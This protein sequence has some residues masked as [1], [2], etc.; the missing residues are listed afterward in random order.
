M[1]AG[2]KTQDNEMLLFP[3][4]SGG[5]VLVR[6]DQIIGARPNGPN[7][8]AIIYSSGGPAY[9]CTLSTPQLARFLDAHIVEQR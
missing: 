3:S 9:Y 4:A 6:R 8:G 5:G 7:D 1:P 2:E